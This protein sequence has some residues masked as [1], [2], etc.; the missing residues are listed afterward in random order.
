MLPESRDAAFLWD[1]LDAA[2]QIEAFLAGTDREVFGR[3]AMRQ[4]A[5]ARQLEIM[6]EAT[7]RLSDAFR[8]AHPQV[9]WRKMVGLRNILI[10]AY[11]DVDL[12]IVA[13]F[14]NPRIRVTHG[15]RSRL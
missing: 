3:D 12:Q 7:Q 11:A 15:T 2:R 13:W 14:K 5:V 4:S 6:G 9:E 1:I 10:H 8:A